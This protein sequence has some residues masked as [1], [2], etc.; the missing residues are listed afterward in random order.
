M[1]LRGARRSNLDLSAPDCFALLAMAFSLVIARFYVIASA[2]KQ[3]RDRR[4]NGGRVAAL[5]AMT[6]RRHRYHGRTR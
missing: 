5:L 4:L 6:R 1:S 2:A 3:S